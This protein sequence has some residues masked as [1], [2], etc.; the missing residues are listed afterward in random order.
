MTS[1]RKPMTGRQ[2]VGV[3]A[4][5][6]ATAALVSFVS[7]W[8]GTEYTPYRDI[9]GVWTVCQGITGRHVIPGKTYSKA[10]CNA[11]LTGELEKHGAEVL[12]C[13]NRPLTDPQQVAVVSW[14]FNVGTAGAC[15]STLVLRLN[16]GEPPSAWCPELMRWNRAGGRPVQGLTNRRAAEMK[17]CLS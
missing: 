3:G 8:E 10:E 1:S 14:A 4:A 6:I 13:I 12:A 5:G 16:A 2:K 11:L 17:L 7:L 15:S 9:V